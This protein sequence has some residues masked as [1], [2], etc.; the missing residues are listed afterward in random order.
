MALTHSSR[1]YF[2]KVFSGLWVFLVIL[3]TPWLLL[4]W[5]PSAVAS[6]PCHLPLFNSPITSPIHLSRSDSSNLAWVY[7][8]LP[9]QLCQV[10]VQRDQP[11]V[12]GRIAQRVSSTNGSPSTVCLRN[13]QTSIFKL[14]KTLHTARHYIASSIRLW[15]TEFNVYN[16]YT[17]VTWLKRSTFLIVNETPD[18]DSSFPH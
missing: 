6:L 8:V 15:G 2:C 17:P 3:A 4:T 13:G 10:A 11:W 1:T 18:L 14:V 9:W 16:I 12:P 7:V 5:P